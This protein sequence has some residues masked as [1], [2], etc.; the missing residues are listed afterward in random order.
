[1]SSEWINSVFPVFEWRERERAENVWI[2]IISLD[3]SPVLKPAVL[4]YF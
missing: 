2:F 4:T 1:M 3:I